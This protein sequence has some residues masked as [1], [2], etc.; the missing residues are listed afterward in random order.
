M[1]TCLAAA[2][3]AFT[4]AYTCDNSLI[5][6][7]TEKE[8]AWVSLGAP[9]HGLSH[10]TVVHS[11]QHVRQHSVP[12]PWVGARPALAATRLPLS[13]TTLVAGG[14]GFAAQQS[15]VA[16]L[17]MFDADRCL[18]SFRETANLSTAGAVPYGGWE[19]PTSLL[20]GHILGGHFLSA[21]SQI[22]NTTGDA[23][24]AQTLQDIVTGLAACQAANGALFGSGYLSAFPPTQF[25]CLEN[26]VSKDCPIWS[27]YYTIAKILRGLYDADTLAG[28]PGAADIA[29]GML[30][31][32]ATRIRSFIAKN[33]ISAWWPL[34]NAEF[35]GMNDVAWLF[36]EA[37]GS[38]DA[39]FLADVAFNKAC[40]L[41]PLAFD[42]DYLAGIHANTHIPIVVGAAQGYEAGGGPEYAA[43]ARGYLDVVEHGHTFATGG[44]SSGEWWGDAHRL[45][46]QLDVNGV[47]SCTTYNTLKVARA[48]FSW[49]LNTSAMDTYE[50]AKYSG[51]HGTMH[52]TAV[53]R[54]IYLLPL[55]GANGAAGGSKAHSYWGWSDAL[56][57]MWCCVGSGMESHSKHGELLFMAQ[58]A[59]PTLLVTLFDDADVAWPVSSAVGGSGEARV[60]QR[61]VW[62]SNGVTV[63]LNVS[64]AAAGATFAVA[65]RIPAW[66]EQPSATLAGTPLAASG[67]WFNTSVRAW[68]ASATALVVSLPFIPRL[69][70]LDDSRSQFAAYAALVAGPFALGALTRVDDV[71]IGANATG[72]APQWVRPLSAAERASARSFAAPALGPAAFIRH[73]NGTAAIA[74]N[75]ALPGGG[76]GGGALTWTLQPAGFL[77]TGNDLFHGPL[78]L[79]AGEAMCANLTLCVGITW[80]GTDPQPSAPV[81]MYLKSAADFTPGAG[82]TSYLNSRASDAL[83][84]D[85][86]GADSTWL[87]DGPLALGGDASL[88]SINRP[89]EYLACPPAAAPCAIAH[90]SSAA[91]NAS[92]TWRVHAPG[93]TGQ[94]A[95]VSY[96]A[97]AQPGAYLSFFGGAAPSAALSVQLL[98]A[99]DGAFANA[100]TFVSAAANWMPGPV[101]YIAQ[102]GDATVPG[103]RDFLLLPVADIASEW[104]GVYLQVLAQ[105]PAGTVASGAREEL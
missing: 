65:V 19:S 42:K 51:M 28:V 5:T 82:W 36:Y 14:R 98:R 102:S 9:H 89:G 56:A 66:A 23:A 44:S 78:T 34:L 18:Y 57:S 39:L 45:G 55:R 54:I 69:E 105:A 80:E 72:S 59:S 63:T 21:A 100:S 4:S 58:E 101:A 64:G 25:D 76:G 2:L 26:G 77:D 48:A 81:D 73:D 92:A 6:G 75:V 11:H 90:G 10:A 3:A 1:R 40:L 91:F 30:R 24:V 62:S 29:A 35:G 16:W 15:T 85:E 12:E 83:G 94:P 33:S 84:G 7:A 27:P 70:S 32:F 17:R 67:A 79:A 53:G 20:R 88:R 71:V 99:G 8:A 103:S 86:D 68:P 46:D 31:Y 50:R 43:A 22:V 52:P 38:A 87:V 93:L 96:E 49:D 95:S 74:A 41:G 13:A 104:Y 97:L 60:S 61:P 37:T 47:E